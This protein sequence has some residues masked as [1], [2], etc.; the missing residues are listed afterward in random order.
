LG[1]NIHAEEKAFIM[2]NSSSFKHLSRINKNI[3]WEMLKNEANTEIGFQIY[4]HFLSLFVLSCQLQFYFQFTKSQSGWR[5]GKPTLRKHKHTV[6][7]RG[8]LPQLC[9]MYCQ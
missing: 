3:Q 1:T 5:R 8:Q 2:Q 6:R 4:M 7:E 9:K